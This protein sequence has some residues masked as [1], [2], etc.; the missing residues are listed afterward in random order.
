MMVYGDLSLPVANPALMRYQELNVRIN[1]AIEAGI[2]LRIA[3]E[4]RRKLQ[5][6]KTKRNTRI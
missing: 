6:N 3:N 2:K 4:R 1:E 5:P